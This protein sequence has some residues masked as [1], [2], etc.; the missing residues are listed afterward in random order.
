MTK[1]KRILSTAQS[2]DT[3]RKSKASF[4]LKRFPCKT[5]VIKLREEDFGVSTPK[6]WFLKKTG[7]VAR[8]DI[9][10]CPFNHM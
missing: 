8:I 10:K 4:R 2:T 3:V 7:T 6:S 1:A 5:N 9:E